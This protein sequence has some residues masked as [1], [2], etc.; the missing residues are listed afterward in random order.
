[1]QKY[2]V[3][4]VAMLIGTPILVAF[5]LID[6][7]IPI[8]FIISIAVLMIVFIDEDISD[9]FLKSF[10]TYPFFFAIF[11]MLI[12]SQ[13]PG[14]MNSIKPA[15]LVIQPLSIEKPFARLLTFETANSIIAATCITGSVIFWV[16]SM[17]TGRGKKVILALAA[18]VAGIYFI[19]SFYIFINPDA[20]AM[21][22][23]WY[24]ATI[25]WFDKTYA[26]EA[27]NFLLTPLKTLALLE[28]YF[29][30]SSTLIPA[31]AVCFGLYFINDILAVKF[32]VDMEAIVRR[33][34]G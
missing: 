8:A 11:L 1:M 3:Y 16:L 21:N 25:E 34:G 26:F 14:I 9:R 30:L 33:A 18:L 31:I 20:A 7:I 32:G 12:N 23:G 17:I 27:L 29:M 22:I 19:E 6:W 10:I 15:A 5:I 13:V 24:R 28:Y 4:R 2:E